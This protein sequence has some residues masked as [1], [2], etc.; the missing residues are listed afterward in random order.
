V[1]DVPPG[2]RDREELAEVAEDPYREPLPLDR[3]KVWKK[4]PIAW[5]TEWI[6]DAVWPTSG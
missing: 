1:D 6:T 2:P 3:G 5:R 4:T